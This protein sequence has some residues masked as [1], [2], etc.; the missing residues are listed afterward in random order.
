[1]EVGKQLIAAEVAKVR[2]IAH[3][4]LVSR[5]SLYKPRRARPPV[6][7]LPRRPVMRALDLDVPL[8]PEQMPG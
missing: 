4:L 6:R 7:R 5:Q 2:P 3:A 1:V 8:G